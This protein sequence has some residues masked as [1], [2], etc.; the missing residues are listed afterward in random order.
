MKRIGQFADKAL[1]SI[2]G[3]IVLV[4][5]GT[6]LFIGCAQVILRYVFNTGFHWSEAVFVLF[7]VTAMLFAGSRAVRDDRHIRVDVL[8]RLLPYRWRLAMAFLADLVAGLLCAYFAYCGL[9]FVL[10]LNLMGTRSPETGLPDWITYLLVPITFGFFT[11]RYIQS[12]R[13][14]ARGTVH[15]Q[16]Q[17]PAREIGDGS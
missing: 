16:H 11:L 17:L 7:T 3:I 2:E 12:L 4:C 5:I 1:S 10:F 13:R 9:R 14:T 6:A 8:P 15:D